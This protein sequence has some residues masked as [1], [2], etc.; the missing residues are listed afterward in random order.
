VERRKAIFSALF[1]CLFALSALSQT[2]NKVRAAVP[3]RPNGVTASNDLDGDGKADILW[4]NSSTGSV[5][6][7]FMNGAT[8]LSGAFVATGVDPAWQIAGIGDFDGDGKADILWR[9]SSTGS[10]VLWLMNGATK[11][12]AAFVATGVDPTWQIAGVGDFDGDGK[13]DILWRNSDSGGVAVWLMNGATTKSAGMVASTVDPNLLIAGV[14]DFDGDGQ[15]DILWRD[16]SDGSVLLWRMSGV[17]EFSSTEVAPGVDPAWQIA[18]LGDFDGDGKADILWRNSST[19]SVVVWLMDG[20]TKLG[21]AFVATGVDPNWQI[22]GVADYDGDGK[23][24]ILWRNNATTSVAVWTM[25]GATRT[26]AAFVSTN[27]DPAWQ[28]APPAVPPLPPGPNFVL[29]VSPKAVTLVSGSTKSLDVSN[30]PSNGFTGQV[31][32]S[33]AGVPPE[34]TASPTTFLL[35]AGGQQ[36]VSFSVP[37]TATSVRSTLTLQGTSGYLT[38][39]L[40]LPLAVIPIPTAAHAP[41]RTRYLRTDA[42]YDPNSLQ[43]APPHLTVYDRVHKL[44]FVSNP[45]LNEIDVFDAALE[46]EVG[47]ISVPAPWGIDIAPDDTVLYAATLLGNVYVID[48]TTFFVIRRVA[49]ASIG[50]NGFEASQALVLADGRVAL[51][52]PM[53]GLPVDGSTTFAVWNPADNS[54]VQKPPQACPMNIGAFALSGDRTRVLLGDID[55]GGGLCSF[56]ASAMTFATGSFGG[57]L[58]QIEPSPD[59][60][61]FFVT[62]ESG[63]IGV[64]DVA[65]VQQLGLFQG[66]QGDSPPQS[67]GIYGAVM[68]LDGGTLFVVDGLS[69]VVAYDTTSF[70]QKGWVPNYFIVDSQ[71]TLVPAA[72]D[73]TGLILGPIGHG[74][75]FLDGSQIQ[76]AVLPPEVGLGYVVPDTGPAAGGTSIQVGTSTGVQN[77]VPGLSQAYI[78]NAPLV[79]AHEQILGNNTD[80]SIL[81]TTPPASGM[82]V[83]DFTAVFQNGNVGLMPES[84]S[85]GPAIVE[86][87]PNASAAEGGTTAMVIGYG[88]GQTVS[89]VHVSIGGHAATVTTLFPSA[90]ISPYPFPVE[91]IKFTVPPGTPGSNVDVKVTTVNGST[92]AGGAFHYTS[93]VTSYPLSATLQAGVYDPYR[94]LYYFTDRTKI[95]VLSTASGQWLTPISLPNVGGSTQLLALSLSPDGSKLAISDFGDRAIYVLNPDAPASAQEFA[96]PQTPLNAGNTPTGLA[97]TDT[98]IVYFATQDL[99]GTGNRIF[100][101]LDTA[102]GITQDLTDLG[103]GGTNDHYIR[104]LLSP[105]GAKIYSLIEGAAFWVD[106]A[107]DQVTYASLTPGGL[108]LALSADGTT[109][110]MNGIFAD[111]SLNASGALTYIDRETWVPTAVLGQ[112]LNHDGS[113]MFQ[114]LTDG[115]DVLDVARGRLLYRV[116]VPVQIAPAYDALVVNP[117]DNTVAAITSNGV[118]LISLNQLPPPST[119]ALSPAPMGAEVSP[120]EGGSS[121]PFAGPG[122]IKSGP[123]LHYKGTRGAPKPPDWR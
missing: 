58:S 101:R 10:V 7:W 3:V 73:E 106:T 51:L 81:G 79:G 32:V 65:T 75:S 34:V 94:S 19:R 46:I 54:L 28:I 18:G 48:P 107:T 50:P 84:F 8:R 26:G 36:Q 121:R 110:D 70:A 9:N 91:G 1:L 78:G 42:Q 24:D 111:A 47:Q 109:L 95:Q 20:A 64:Y 62:S 44:F 22:V 80:P 5:V 53:G 102:S 114:P 43:F 87:V 99:N 56:D 96:V 25:D 66:P 57:F 97:I 90:P 120:P 113:L 39:T 72:I 6:V 63:R 14:A 69:D 88:F 123:R 59:G 35:A 45:F 12:G 98:G 118:T 85:Y 108:E 11:V 77:T 21:S 60:K 116:E 112:K 92:T 31:S 93:A 122:K 89:D 100:H 13:A 68:S 27:V 40:Q 71:R 55:S 17:T 119:T 38:R 67:L 74:V 33:I 30:T 15:A 49:A 41:L 29:S 105:D 52:G 4:R 115:I 104:V 76:P 23:A 61:R 117:T 82:V 2:S 86:V 37:S 103:A 83:A 16:I